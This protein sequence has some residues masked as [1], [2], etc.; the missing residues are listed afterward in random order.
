MTLASFKWII[1][2]NELCI[3]LKEVLL[4]GVLFLV[5]FT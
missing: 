1:W 2:K 3:S 4:D 5:F